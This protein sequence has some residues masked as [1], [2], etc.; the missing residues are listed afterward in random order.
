MRGFLFWRKLI[1]RRHKSGQYTDVLR[2][3]QGTFGVY[4]D[5]NGEKYPYNFYAALTPLAKNS[6]SK[7]NLTHGRFLMNS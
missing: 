6:L 4:I 3:P 5:K 2:F 7:L 1:N